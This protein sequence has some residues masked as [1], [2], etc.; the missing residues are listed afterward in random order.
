MKNIKEIKG[1][2]RESFQMVNKPIIKCLTSL[3]FREIKIKYHYTPDT[4][5]K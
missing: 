4:G 1:Q 2:K 5:L 3:Q